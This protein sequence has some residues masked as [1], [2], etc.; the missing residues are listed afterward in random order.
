MTEGTVVIFDFDDT[1]IS[2][3]AGYEKPAN[4]ES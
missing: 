3:D 4:I 1:L 2:E